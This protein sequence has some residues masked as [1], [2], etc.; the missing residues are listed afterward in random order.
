[1]QGRDTWD[2]APFTELMNSLSGFPVLRKLL[3][4]A[5]L[6]YYQTG[7]PS[8]GDGSAISRILPLSIVSLQLVV[9]LEEMGDWLREC[10]SDGLLHLAEAAARGQF[11]HLKSVSCVT[12]EG[13]D[14]DALGDMFAHAG[15]DF[16]YDAWT[17]PRRL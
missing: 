13:V 3:L 6:L 15:V 9:G 14:F 5:E 4:S 1:V 12:K 2:A 16:G 8:D 7:E 11:P 17:W 10:L